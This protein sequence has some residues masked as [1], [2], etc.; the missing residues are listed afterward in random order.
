MNPNPNFGRIRKTV[1]H[2]EPDRVPIVEIL[3]EYPIISRFLGRKVDA[4]DLAGQV[5]FWWK[6]GYDY[7]PLT[8]GMMTPG[9]VTEDSAISRIIKARLKEQGR[10]V[11]EKSWNLEFNSFINSRADFDRFPWD[12][13]AQ[14]ATAH[15]EAI[16]PMLPAGMKVITLSGK[17][18]TLSCMLMGFEEF[19]MSLACEDGLAADVMKMAAKVQTEAAVKALAMDHVGAVWAVDDIAATNT[20]ML[21]PAMLK[22]WLFP[23]YESMA[24]KCHSAGKLFFYHTDGNIIPVIDDMIALGVDGLHPIDPTSLDIRQVKKQYGDR[25]CLLG[26]VPTELLRSGTTAEVET[27]VKDLI[28]DIAPGGGFCL[29]SGNSVPEWANLDNYNTMRETALRCGTYPIGG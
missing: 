1:A 12:I 16:Q 29:G 13:A 24:A 4:A 25:V 19:S 22:K 3:V 26:N 9:K 15:I 8:V 5:E 18:Y 7:V 21:S 2:Q 28:R 20:T 14:V 23:W 10:D 6:A 11:D 27:Y 17:I